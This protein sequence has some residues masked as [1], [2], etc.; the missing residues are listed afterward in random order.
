MV[1]QY[2][3]LCLASK[4]TIFHEVNLSSFCTVCRW[5][6]HVSALWGSCRGSV[7]VLGDEAAC[8]VA[9]LS[10]GSSFPWAAGSISHSLG[11]VLIIYTAK[12]ALSQACKIQKHQASATE[13]K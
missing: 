9:H 8:A 1:F 3:G 12:P 10:N 4:L 2:L 13:R 11:C 5:L 7:P 6:L